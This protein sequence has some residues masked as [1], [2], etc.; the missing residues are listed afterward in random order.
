MIFAEAPLSLTKSSSAMAARERG[1]KLAEFDVKRTNHFGKGGKKKKK[2]TAKFFWGGG[3]KKKQRKRSAQAI[4]P[5]SYR[6][7]A[8]TWTWWLSQSQNRL[9]LSI[10]AYQHE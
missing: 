3:G 7:R 5:A 6:S 2:S 10:A 8:D 1:R 4:H 9:G